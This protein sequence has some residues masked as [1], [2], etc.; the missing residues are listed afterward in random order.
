MAQPANNYI[1]KGNEA[2]RKGDFNTA[3]EAYKN[4]LRKDPANTTARFNLANAQQKQ[5]EIKE[6]NKNYD[7]VIEKASVNSIKAESNYNKGLAHLKGKDLVQAIASFK[8]SL[9][10]DPNDDDAREN[11]QK[12]LNEL[13]KQQ[14]QNKPQNNQQQK[15]Q[16]QK[17]QKQQP[18]NKAMMQQKFNELR[19]Q[20]KQLQQ[21]LQ[22]KNNT[23]QP[24]KDW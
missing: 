20:E 2:Y 10:E 6:A 7:E 17:K 9:K 14:Q 12:A 16:D 4:A 8:A 18:L 15:Q 1:Q 3:I 24:E 21:K 19:N 23:L 11:L 5:N 22:S 13:K